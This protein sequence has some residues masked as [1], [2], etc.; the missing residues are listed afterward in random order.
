MSFARLNRPI[1]SG[2]TALLLLMVAGC[3]VN[4][5]TGNKQLI[6]YSTEQEL[7]LGDQYHPNLIYMYDGRYREAE[8]DRYLTTIVDRIHNVSHRREMRTDFTLLNTSIY[9]A[10]AI[11]GHV[12]ATRGFVAKLENEAQFAAVMGHEMAHVTSLHTANQMTTNVLTSVGVGIAQT[13]IGESTGAQAAAVA[14]QLSVTLLGLSYSREQERQADRVGTYYMA[15][16]GWD[17]REAI[18]MQRLLASMNERQPTFMD[19]YLST[20]PQADNRIQEIRAV[21]EERDLVDGGYIQGD[22]IFA[23]RWNRY[24]SGLREVDKA[25]EPYDRGQKL[26]R[27]KKYDE[28]LAAANEALS[29]RTDQ[30]PFHRL[31]GDAL[32][33]LE[34]AEQAGRAYQD[35]LQRDPSYVL[36]N[37][38]LG[39]VAMVQEQYAEAERQFATAVKAFPASLNAQYGL[40]LARIKLEKFREAIEPL[41]TVTEAAPKEPQPHYYLA[42]AYYRTR[43]YA[44]ALAHYRAALQAGLSGEAASEARRR[45]EELEARLQPQQ[46]PQ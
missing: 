6:F 1:A 14:G 27:E 18:S 8:V 11:P 29:R 7:A 15:M 16:G 9:N 38:G 40:G 33:G 21:I 43:Q 30:A 28:A 32:L 23:D 34:Q 19:K 4:P 36:A 2:L 39:R 24:M 45:S 26:I 25:Y 46:S 41:R 17:A 13:V 3:R 44:K 31:K 12:Y 10:F 42:V 37:I 22:G 20:H 35:S 5:V